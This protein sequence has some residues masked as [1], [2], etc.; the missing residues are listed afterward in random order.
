MLEGTQGTAT[1]TARANGSAGRRRLRALLG[2]VTSVAT[3]IA[4]VGFSVALFF[5]PVWIGF[6]QTRAGVPAITGWSATDVEAVT[7]A[8]LADL[9]LGPPEFD[10]VRAGEPVLDSRERSHMVDV[11]NV[12]IPAAMLFGLALAELAVVLTAGHRTAWV[13]RAIARG[14][15]ALAVLGV[16]VGV[17]VLF[18]FD[19]AFLLFHLVV[20][21]QG[22]FL[23][24]P[25]TQRLTQLFPEQ[26]WVETSIGIS[27]VGLMVAVAV[28]LF[29]RHRAVRLAG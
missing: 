15:G 1:V 8:I 12:L 3:A 19:A 5:N 17:A 27:I 28:T 7:G 10:V 21:P 2:G 18:F 4:I 20:F 22:N 16:V 9:V 26:F 24:D 11:R 25:R 23:F 14:S 29:A 6:E 13:W